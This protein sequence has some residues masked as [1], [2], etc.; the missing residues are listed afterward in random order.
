MDTNPNIPASLQKEKEATAKSLVKRIALN[1]AIVIAI[2]L[3]FRFMLRE[4]T[5]A[6]ID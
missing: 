6:Q 3:F 1:L 4:R 5:N 2:D